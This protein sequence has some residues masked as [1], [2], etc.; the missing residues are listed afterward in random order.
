VAEEESHVTGKGQP[1]ET[2]KR[3]DIFVWANPYPD[4][5]PTDQYVLLTDP[6]EHDGRLDIS[7]LNTGMAFVPINRVDR[8][9]MVIF[10]VHAPTPEETG[11]AKPKRPKRK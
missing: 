2:L 1:L 6:G 4:E 5:S 7:P 10:V 8:T 9:D 11:E 3:G